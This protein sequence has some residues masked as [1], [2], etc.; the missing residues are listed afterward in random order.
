M[1][2]NDSSVENSFNSTAAE[3]ANILGVRKFPHLRVY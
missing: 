1:V 3:I 2:D